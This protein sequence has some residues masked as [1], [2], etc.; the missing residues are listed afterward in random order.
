[1]KLYQ[2]A[3]SLLAFCGM[4]A[5]CSDDDWK[6]DVSALQHPVPSSIVMLDEAGG[7]IVKGNSFQLRFRVNPSSVVLTKDNV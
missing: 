7:T 2:T 6:D 4:L 3:F 1:M 5:A